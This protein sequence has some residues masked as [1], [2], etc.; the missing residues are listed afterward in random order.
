MSLFQLIWQTISRSIPH[1]GFP[2]Y[3]MVEFCFGI[4]VSRIVFSARKIENR[5]FWNF[6]STIWS[7]I[8]WKVSP[9]S[10]QILHRKSEKEEFLDWRNIQFSIFQLFLSDWDHQKT[11]CEILWRQNVIDWIFL[12]VWTFSRDTHVWKLSKFWD[13][14]TR[15]V[16][17]FAQCFWVRMFLMK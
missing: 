7:L 4:S 13:K 8:Y 10:F 15:R 17:I 14:V 5:G 1:I 9:S 3:K 12:I 2:F 11:F 16:Q 6:C